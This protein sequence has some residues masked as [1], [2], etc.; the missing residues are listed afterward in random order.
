VT[1]VR[2]WCRKFHDGRTDIHDEGGQGWPPVETDDLVQHVDK[3]VRERCRFTISELSL[4]FPQVSGMVLYEIVTKKLGYHK[5]CARWVP[6]M[7]T[8]VQKTQR[9]ALVSTFLQYYD[10]EGD[11]FLDKI[12]IGDETWVKF[13]N[14]ETKEQSRQWMHT[15]S[16]LKPR[17][18]K[19]LSDRKLMATV[20][21][22]RKGVLLIEFMEPGTMIT[23]ETYCETLNKLRRAIQNKRRGMLTSGVVLLHNSTC[24]HTAAYTQALLQQ[25]CWDL[26]DHPPYSPDLAPSDFHLFTQMKVWLGAQCFNMNEELMD[27]VKDWLSSQVATLFDVGLQKLVSCYI[28][29]LNSEGDY[30]EK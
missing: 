1:H 3:L 30:V 8:D 18:L 27:G 25:F 2:E 14:V 10:D 5:F 23:S 6:K 29:S 7:L 21:W 20:S 12:V 19:Q 24:P 9:M 11:E 4:E 22:D 17:K 15:H 28:K 26:F 16:L 13:A